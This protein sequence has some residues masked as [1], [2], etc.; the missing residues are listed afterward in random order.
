MPRTSTGARS[1][2]KPP[3]ARSTPA[4]LGAVGTGTVQRVV[5]L[6]SEIA[7]TKGEQVGV[8][9]LAGR[10][11]LPTPTTHRLLHLLREGGMVEWNAS[12]KRYSVGPELYRIAAL[13]NAA[14][15]LPKIAQREIRNVAEKT[16][17]ATLFGVYLPNAA[18]MSFIAQAD[19]RH[20]LQY[21]IELNAITSLVW[22]ASGKAILA[23]L[24][25]EVVAE[26]LAR[27][28][29]NA[30]GSPPP[31]AQRLSEELARVRRNGFAVSE[32]EK[33]QGARGVAAPVFGRNGIVGSICV[34][35]P[36][37][38]LPID[39]VTELGDIVTEAAKRLSRSLGAP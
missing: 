32:G 25:E 17:E 10:L 7:S 21:R 39:S 24:P 13:V 35:S 9:E 28:K 31:T 26:A 11:E 27:E 4:A 36:R 3:P 29:D 14:A 18:A 12:T 38:R 30:S 1:G 2:K 33:L 23:F 22:G 19:G 6:L 34:T 5:R 15:D 16:G 20:A 8:A 37:E